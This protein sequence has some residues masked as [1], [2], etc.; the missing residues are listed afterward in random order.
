MP[1]F[2]DKREQD[3][4]ADS[5]RDRYEKVLKLKKN[6]IKRSKVKSKKLTHRFDA[7]QSQPVNLEKNFDKAV[8]RGVL[9]NKNHTWEVE[10]PTE[11]IGNEKDGA[12]CGRTREGGN[13]YVPVSKATCKRCVNAYKRARRKARKIPPITTNIP[14]KLEENLV[15]AQNTLQH[16]FQTALV[17]WLCE[18]PTAI[19]IK[20]SKAQLRVLTNALTATKSLYKSLKEHVTV[21]EMITRITVKNSAAQ[22]FE[23]FFGISWPL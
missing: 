5:P 22:Q 2:D 13:I 8:D 16:V 1:L 11:H 17:S 7:D 6:K 12:L 23:K 4:D 15:Q 14:P 20:G 3:K 10:L 9:T 21:D 19:K 18:Q